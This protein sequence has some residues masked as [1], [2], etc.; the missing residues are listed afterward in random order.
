MIQEKAQKNKN[1]IVVQKY[2]GTSVGS[3]ERIKEVAK[4]VIRHRDRGDSIVVVVSAM[5]GETNKLVTLI[6]EL[7]PTGSA[8][9]KDMVLSPS[10]SRH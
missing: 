9:E 5:S 3:A 10:L 1:R 7:N 8:R 2:G 4:R 6:N